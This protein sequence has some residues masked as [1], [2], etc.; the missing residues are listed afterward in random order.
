CVAHGNRPRSFVRLDIDL[1]DLASIATSEPVSTHIH[2]N[3]PEP[4]IEL[5]R[6]AEPGEVLPGGDERVLGC[7]LGVGFGTQDGK[8]R[9]VQATAPGGDERVEG[10]VVASGGTLDG[11]SVDRSNR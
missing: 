7:V 9:P 1:S 6:V 4:G 10:G 5:L 11:G 8:G 3:P 2:E